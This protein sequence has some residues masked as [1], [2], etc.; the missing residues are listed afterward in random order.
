MSVFLYC[1]V[2]A[3][4]LSSVY[5]TYIVYTIQPERSLLRLYPP[6]LDAGVGIA[7]AAAAAPHYFTIITMNVHSLPSAIL[8]HNL[9]VATVILLPLNDAV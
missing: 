1:V 6:M 2:F 7:I 3:T 5:T 9:S 8:F 4:R